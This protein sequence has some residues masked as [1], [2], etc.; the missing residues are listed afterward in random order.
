[1]GD[2]LLN[3]YG[4]YLVVQSANNGILK[5]AN[6][7]RS[8]VPPGS[9]VIANALHAEDIRLFSYG[10]I[11]PL[12]T[13]RAGIPRDNDSVADP[14]ELAEFLKR[15]RG[16]K[17]VY[18]LDVDFKYTIEKAGY[19]AHKYVRNESVAMQKIGLIH[20]SQAL[21]PYL[22]PLKALITRPYISFLGSPDLENDFY[23]GPAQDGT[24]FFREVYAEYHVY[25]VTGT[26]VA[27]WDPNAPW[28]FVEE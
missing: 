22:D 28:R 18:F 12:W 17:E 20:T 16:K 1:M 9:I 25:K 7:F 21:Y 6:W 26:E 13:V 15:V 10:H 23:R 3:P 5:M 24:A 11:T 8:R 2:Q 4:S 19:H 14:D 27:P